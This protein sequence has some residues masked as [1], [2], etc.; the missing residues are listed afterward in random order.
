MRPARAR[1]RARLYSPADPERSRHA[2]LALGARA[3]W[4]PIGCKR[5]RGAVYAKVQVPCYRSAFTLSR[6]LDTAKIDAALKD[7]VL[8]LRIPKAEHAQPRRIEVRAS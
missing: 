8:T 4:K 6:E 2:S 3:P 1:L 7:G 5:G